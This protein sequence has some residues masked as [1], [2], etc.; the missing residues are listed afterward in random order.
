MDWLIYCYSVWGVGGL[1]VT[2]TLSLRDRG[3]LVSRGSWLVGAGGESVVCGGLL[4]S[5][6]FLTA[7]GRVA[8]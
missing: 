2:R 3:E 7:G 8:Y 1:M 5:R 6:E 4:M